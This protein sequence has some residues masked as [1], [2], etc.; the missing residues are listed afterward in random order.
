LP[1][2]THQGKRLTPSSPNATIYVHNVYATDRVGKLPEGAKIT[3]MRIVQLFPKETPEVD[4][5]RIGYGHQA[6]ARMILGTVPV[7]EDGSVYCK[8]PVAKEIYFQL[9]DETG[10]AIQS[11]RSGT[12]VHPGEQMSCLGCHESRSAA[13]ARTAGQVSKALQRAPSELT[14]EGGVVEP[15]NFH[16]L[17]KPVFEGKCVACHQRK[18]QGGPKDMSYK[19]MAPYVF[20]FHGGNGGQLEKVYGGS[21][22]IPGFFGARY[23]RMGK[24]L[25]NTTHQDALKE[26]AYSREDYE[27]VVMW[28]DNMST[29][30]GAYF[31]VDRQQRGELVWPK[32]DVDPENPQGVERRGLPPRSEGAYRSPAVEK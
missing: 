26:G 11:M 3:R 18:E 29:E 5:P 13:P 2:R 19:S 31:N 10:M 17:I 7:E 23:S 27:R 15:L 8:A 22:T 28:L 32:L 14:P 21:R 30:L 4:K 1:T 20:F 6:L 25:L 9:L 24:A 12:Y 16:R